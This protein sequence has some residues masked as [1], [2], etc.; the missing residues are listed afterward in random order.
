MAQYTVSTTDQAQMAVLPVRHSA[1]RLLALSGKTVVVDEAHALD[2]FSQLQ[3]LR[4]LQW[5]GALNCPVVLLSATMPASTATE[6]V[7]T[8]LWGAGRAG[9]HGTSFAPGYPGWLFADAATAAV[10]RMPEPAQERT[11]PRPP[12][13]LPAPGAGRPYGRSGGAPGGG[14]RRAPAGHPPRRVRGRGVRDRRRDAGHLP[15]PAPH[16]ERPA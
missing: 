15:V 2:P 7:R 12:G 16:L 1:L 5:L 8:Y 4:L 13:H 9:L 3:L 6:L 14:R 10:H 11:H